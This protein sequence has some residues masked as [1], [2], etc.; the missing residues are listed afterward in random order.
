MGGSYFCAMK[1]FKILIDNGHGADTPGKRSPDA[2]KGLWDSKYY[3]FEYSWCREIARMCCDILQAEG[4]DAELLTPE[5]LDTPLA[6]R[7]KRVNNWCNKLGK[8]NV[9]LISIH[10]N[11]CGMGDAW[12]QAR[13]WEIYTTKGITEADYLAE[14][15]YKVAK[16][17]FKYPLSIRSG[18]SK[19]LTHD[20]EEN[21]Y[22][23]F[24]TYCPAVLVENFF[25]DNKEDVLFLKST[26]GKASCAHVIVQ[27]VENYI[28]TK[29]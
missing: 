19:P 4:Y 28:K 2:A 18:G 25:Q 9:L 22:I 8:N 17:E 26:K 21:F 10:N 1:K 23:I 24:K 11:A 3:F 29:M 5:V 27:G 12:K 20:K 13:G 7:V 16:T 6:T 15:I 14:E